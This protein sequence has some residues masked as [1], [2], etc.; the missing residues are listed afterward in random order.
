[1]ELSGYR[2]K[3]SN[4]DAVFTA[5]ADPTRRAILARLADGQA[6]V[7]E[8]AAPFE[9][10]QPAISKHL[11]VLERANLIERRIDRQRR[12][13]TLSAKGMAAA[14]EWLAEYQ[15]FWDTSF[16]QLQNVLAQIQTPKEATMSETAE[17]VIE[18]L[19]DA[20]RTLV[21]R[22]WT[23]PELLAR[24]YG[25]GIETIIH[26]YDLRPGGVWLNEM[27]WGDKSDLS[28][29]AFL[30]VTPEEQ[31]VWH[32]SSTDRDWNIVANPMMPDWPRVL[33]TTVDFSEEGGQ[34]K[35]R[36]SQV[37]VDATDAE[38]A[39]F[40]NMMGGM[41][42]GWGSGFTIMDEI[43][44]ELERNPKSGNRFSE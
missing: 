40:A 16:D 5:L 3:I 43:L 26:E 18:H 29:M 4:L 30:D 22:S 12:P 7:Q 10:S 25:P 6:S 2:D 38:T 8:I 14:F 37:P 36:L 28:K 15:R 32:H 9:I 31:I 11:K 20:K 1:M 33:L 34:T 41:G 39:C 35:V 42:K 13:A 23:D 24:W 27:K 19:F 21:W 44:R 17:Y